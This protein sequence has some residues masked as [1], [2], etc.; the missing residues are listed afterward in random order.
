MGFRPEGIPIDQP[1]ELGYK[2]PVGK[3]HHLEW[4]EYNCFIWCKTCNYDWPSCLCMSNLKNATEIF[5]DIIEDVKAK[6]I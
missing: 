6:E 3:Q 5:L 1:S 4:S 2:C